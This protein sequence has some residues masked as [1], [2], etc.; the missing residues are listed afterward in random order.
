MMALVSVLDALYAGTAGAGPESRD[1]P[2]ADASFESLYDEH[3]AFVWRSLRRLGV[4]VTSLDDAVQDVFVVVHRRLDTFEK[5]SSART[6]LFGIVLRVAR[7]HRRSAQRK[8]GHGLVQEEAAATEGVADT[9][10]DPFES[11]AR[12][13]AV[14]LLYTILDELDDDKREVL[15]LADLEQVSVPEIAE[16]LDANVN[17]VHSRLRAARTQVAEALTRH[18]ARDAWR[19]R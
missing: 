5:R 2:A 13:E 9:A 14:R 17:T 18:R 7:T 11:A 19:Q 1:A 15:V 3:F 16:L 4:E 8:R 10:P 12:A 6:W